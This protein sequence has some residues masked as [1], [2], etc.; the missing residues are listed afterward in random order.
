MWNGVA[1]SIR[2]IFAGEILIVFGMCRFKTFPAIRNTHNAKSL[3]HTSKMIDFKPP[4]TNA[5]WWKFVNL[6]IAILY[7]VHKTEFKCLVLFSFALCVSFLLLLSMIVNKLLACKRACVN[8]WWVDNTDERQKKNI[9]VFIFRL[10]FTCKTIFDDNYRF[11]VYT[12]HRSYL[13]SGVWILTISCEL[14]NM[15]DGKKAANPG[16]NSRFFL[17]LVQLKRGNNYS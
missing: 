12:Q 14:I 10:C 17:C 11:L 16:T 8:W 9:L 6:P 13:Y 4:R 1:I 3:F 15:L 5:K 2:T 7:R